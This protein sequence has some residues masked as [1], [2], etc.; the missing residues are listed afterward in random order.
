MGKAENV[1]LFAKNT[2][3]HTIHK[4]LN[5][6]SNLPQMDFFNQ[7]SLVSRKG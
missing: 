4:T 7:L 2:H 5:K 3:E 1:D 6:L